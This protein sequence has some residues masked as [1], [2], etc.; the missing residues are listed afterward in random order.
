MKAEI[1]VWSAIGHTPLTNRGGSFCDLLVDT[2]IEVS[3]IAE[4]RIKAK[5]FVRC[6]PEGN[7]GHYNLPEHPNQ[8]TRSG[9]VG[10][11]D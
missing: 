3:D 10:L 6:T 4:A 2:V 5:Q 8:N 9:Y 1:K 7:T 11:S